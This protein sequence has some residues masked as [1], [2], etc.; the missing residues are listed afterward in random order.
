MLREREGEGI[1]HRMVT[2]APAL[3]WIICGI[4][5]LASTLTQ[6]HITLTLP[7]SSSPEMNELKAWNPCACSPH[8]RQS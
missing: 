5:Y 3:E 6:S 4:A 7:V 2:V 1:E 8:L